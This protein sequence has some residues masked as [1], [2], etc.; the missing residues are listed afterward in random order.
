MAGTDP[1]QHAEL[2]DLAF[3]DHDEDVPHYL[4]LAIL[5]DGPVLELGAGTGRLTLP[6][7]QSGIPLHAVDRSAA[8]LER[9]RQ[10]LA[11]EPPEVKERVQVIE[12]DW[13]ALEGHY[14][15]VLLPFG[16]LHQAASVEDLTRLLTAAAARLAPGGRLALD[17]YLDDPDL[18]ARDPDA[19]H[20]VHERSWRGQ[21]VRCS[22]TARWEPAERRHHVVFRFDFEDGRREQMAFSLRIF[23]LDELHEA[24]R[25]A[26]LIVL[27]EEADY[28]GTPLDEDATEWV[29][30][31]GRATDAISPAPV[32]DPE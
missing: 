12:R 18:Y 22:E 6:L 19:E 25:R 31:L 17:A 20:E 32:A 7:A 10:A 5:A 2:Y 26:G 9:L 24:V 13:E 3:H 4:S 21:R 27:K 11:K 1:Y 16:S 14:E 30:L 8:M 28:D 15:L 23:R 29:A